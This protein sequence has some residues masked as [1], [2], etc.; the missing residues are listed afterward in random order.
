M[1]GPAST[2]PAITPASS[3]T[4]IRPEELP[5]VEPPSAGYIVQ[6]FLIPALIVAAV[7]GVWALFG[8]LADSDTDWQQL[9]SELGSANEHRRWRA[10]LGL[11]HVLKNEQLP[12]D[13]SGVPLSEQPAV[14][15]AL[16]DLFKESLA[17]N[18]TL[19]DDIK[20][21][22]FLARTL[23]SLR[24]D[25]VVVPVLIMAMEADQNIEVRKSSMMSLAMIAGHH[26]EEQAAAQNGTT[27]P[28]NRASGSNSV[29]SLR[30]PL[31]Q[32]TLS[33]PA[34]SEKLRLAAQDEDPIIR[35]LAAY[36]LALVSGDEA[37]EAL[38]LLLSDRDEKARAN[39]VIGLARNGLTDGIPVLTKFLADG[40]AESK[41][42][43]SAADASNDAVKKSAN[44]ARRSEQTV[45]LSN[46]IRAAGDLWGSLTDEQ[47]QELT[48]L[49]QQ[50]S[51]KHS[52]VEVRQEALTVINRL[53]KS[54]E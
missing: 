22:D 34:V 51:E 17:S 29:M 24:V 11:A 27:L 18:S 37:I 21:Q 42:A 47:R 49:L 45:I 32:P 1:T 43:V 23:G 33:D 15:N 50:L 30:Q 19:E 46:C 25:E 4:Q 38:K 8:K 54:G 2:E 13:E 53:A 44:D 9:V 5:P 12:A 35:H 39:A 26:F 36:V 52:S 7:I 14:A 31:S 40:L 3:A 41:P 6:L 10:A 48:P 16:T 20:H 28:Q